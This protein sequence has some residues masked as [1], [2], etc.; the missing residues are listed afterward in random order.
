MADHSV[1]SPAVKEEAGEAAR[2]STLVPVRLGEVRFP[3]TQSNA[4]AFWDGKREHVVHAR[5]S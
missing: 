5:S 1:K 3:K 2:R 4:E